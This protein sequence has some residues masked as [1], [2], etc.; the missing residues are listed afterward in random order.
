[1]V[2]L[3]RLSAFWK[4]HA[5][6]PG[7]VS[8][9]HYATSTAIPK[10]IP[11][12]RGISPSSFVIR[13]YREQVLFANALEKFGAYNTHLFPE[14]KHKI[15][16]TDLVTLSSRM[17][18]AVSTHDISALTTLGKQVP[19]DK[20][21]LKYLKGMVIKSAGVT[22]LAFQLQQNVSSKLDRLTGNC[23]NAAFVEII[24]E[25]YSFNWLFSSNKIDISDIILA[26]D[27]LIT[28][29]KTDVQVSTW[30]YYMQWRATVN[31]HPTKLLVETF[32]RNILRCQSVSEFLASTYVLSGNRYSKLITPL[33]HTRIADLIAELVV[34]HKEAI[35]TDITLLAA[36]S[37]TRHNLDLKSRSGPN[38]VKYSMFLWDSISKNMSHSESELSNF[39]VNVCLKDAISSLSKSDMKNRPELFHKTFSAIEAIFP[40]LYSQ[41]PVMAIKLLYGTVQ[42]RH[43]NLRVT[44][45]FEKGIR[46]LDWSTVRSKEVCQFYNIAIF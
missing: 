16:D 20:E 42:C 2:T 35:S 17:R 31:T 39:S 25:L 10:K 18:D 37:I 24:D 23:S 45:M 9:T 6:L 29:R 41:S 27:R 38:R 40:T 19:K 32:C 34:Q 4:L 44:K 7:K 26:F 3:N 30:C 1:M 12:T 11:S 5:I 8:F 14:I 13:N 33:Y 21:Q 36:L 43:V 46:N 22:L 28:N 15:G